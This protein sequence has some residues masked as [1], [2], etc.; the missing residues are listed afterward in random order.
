MYSFTISGQPHT[1]PENAK[2]LTLGQFI[3]IQTAKS[4]LELLTVLLG[5]EPTVNV[6][7]EA[8]VYK[9]NREMT[10]VYKLIHLLQEDVMLCINSGHLLVQPKSVN[11]LGLD[12][13][14]KPNFINTLQYWGY[15]H[16]REAIKERAQQGKDDNFVATDLIPRILAHNLYCLVTK[17]PYNEAKAEEF[18]EVIKTMSFIEAIQLGNFFLLQQKGLWVSRRKRWSMFLTMLKFKLVSMFLIS[19]VQQTSSKLLAEETYLNGKP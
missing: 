3:D 10:S 2:E 8:D 19:T 17:S 12:V 16:T 9:L 4:E 14:L 7:S 1:I 6:Q 11:V 13:E 18:I 15:I 5:S